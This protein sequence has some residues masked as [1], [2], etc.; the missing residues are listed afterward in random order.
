MVTDA[1]QFNRAGWNAWAEAGGRWSVP[2][3]GKGIAKAR[4][5]DWEV[6]LTPAK[7]VPRSWFGDRSEP[8]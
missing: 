1:K 7:P 8:K 2:V 4:Q 5:G 6:F 3:D